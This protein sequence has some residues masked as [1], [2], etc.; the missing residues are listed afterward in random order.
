[1]NKK[2]NFKLLLSGLLLL[3]GINLTPDAHAIEA[4]I[5]DIAR[6]EG[7]YGETLLGYGL[8]G[9]LNGTG[10][11]N[12]EFTKASMANLLERYKLSLAADDISSKNVAAVLVT[13][14]AP[15]FHRPGDNIDVQV[16]TIG[17]C[18]SLEGGVLMMTPML[19]AGGKLYALAQGAL[20]TG[21]FSVGDAGDGGQVD[22]RNYT[23]VATVPGG[24][25]LRLGQNAE[26]VKDSIMRLVLRNPDFTTANRVADA[27][28]HTFEGAAYARDGG[29]VIVR[30]PSEVIDM[31]QEARF[32]ATMESL[33]LVPDTQAKIVVNERTGTIVMG[34]DVH[35]GPAIVAHGNLTVRIT[36]SLATYMPE[37]FTLAQPVVTP[38][39]RVE[40]KEEKANIML[41]PGTTTVHELAEML[42]QLGSTPRDIISILE[43]LKRLGALQ[44]E[45]ET[46]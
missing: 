16:S 43:A 10:D 46:M 19:N 26:F 1:M 6:I 8:V 33:T 4:R 21:G 37:S 38:E 5:K 14:K 36:S 22:I 28:N 13:A 25:V 18:T 41:L 34:G 2:T 31:G 17:D 12:L 20:V 32:V 24:A 44:M 9:G 27:I 35:I 30:V 7:L 3:A 11:K 29:S 45:L 42:N 15:P 39:T 40:K 23:T